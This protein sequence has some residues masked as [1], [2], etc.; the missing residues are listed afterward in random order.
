[1]DTPE[2]V[3]P[4]AIDRL[5]GPSPRERE[6][7][8]QIGQIEDAF[9]LF[10]LKH[11]NFLIDAAEGGITSMH[12]GL[13]QI[14]L[15]IDAQGWTNIFEYDEDSGLT[16]RQVKAAS[17]QIRELLVGNPF[18]GNGAR[19]R[20]AHVWA[21][22]CD[23]SG[24]LRTGKQE[25]KPLPVVT[26]QLMETPWAQRY[27]FGNLA[28]GE[29][30]RAAF[31]DGTIFILGRESDKR[32]QRIQIHEIQGALHNPNNSEEIWAYRRVWTPNPQSPKDQQ[33][34]R[35]RWYYT[36]MVP[37]ADRRRTIHIRGQQPEIAEPEYT[38][39]D[40][41]FNRQIGWAFGVP[42]ALCVIAWSRLYKEFLTNGYVMSRSLARLAYRIT[43][44]N[45]K[46]GQNAATE[47]AQPGQAGGAYIEGSGN[48]LTPLATAGRGYDFASGNGLAGA[49]AAGLGVSLLALLS[50]PSAATGS[51]AA[52]QTLDPI[53]KATAAVRRGEWG[54]HYVRLFRFYG[55]ERKLVTTWHDLP[56]ETLQRQMQAWVNVANTGLF[57][58]EVSQIG[59]AKTMGIPEPGIIP[60]GYLQPNN[61][62]S[63]PRKDI[64]T[65]GKPGSNPSSGSGQGQ[66]NP[67]GKTPDDH[68]DDG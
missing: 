15:M 57:A 11:E 22:G 28:H 18:I 64:D 17:K 61:V 16:L 27:L 25:V 33:E 49:I 67:A 24:K 19:I 10:S 63:L 5:I 38:M 29:L 62:K 23:F 46:A 7:E 36:D 48:Q 42:D 56:E 60:D 58:P 2:A 8:R 32:V 21:G 51:N 66:P 6:L 59:I 20:T 13:A 35:V 55:M 45:A 52:A 31:S 47:I 44:A 12:E 3:K 53:A 65:D 41:G 37:L 34:E 39:L 26:Q 4:R 14:D 54:D 68:D 43:A 30:E 9:A 50:N 1:M 40:F